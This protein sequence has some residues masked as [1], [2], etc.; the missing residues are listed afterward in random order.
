MLKFL[1]KPKLI[2]ASGKETITKNSNHQHTWLVRQPPWQ[3]I[4]QLQQQG[5][6]NK[7]SG[8]IENLIYL[9]QGRKGK[10]ILAGEAAVDADNNN[11]QKS[12]F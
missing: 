10:T 4:V 1:E 11:S 8:K 9:L 7:Q 5:Q 3:K 2:S 6:S 12:A